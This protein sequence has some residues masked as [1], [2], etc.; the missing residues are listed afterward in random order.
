MDAHKRYLIDANTLLT[1]KNLYYNF[2]IAPTFWKRMKACAKEGR[3][4]TIDKVMKEWCVSKEDEDKDKLQLWIEN[5]F[6]AEIVQT[7]QTKIIAGYAKILN[8]IQSSPSYNDRALKAW[9]EEKIADAWLI[10]TCME[11]DYVL[12]TLETSKSN[13]TPS[14]SKPKIPDFC[15]YFHVPCIDLFTMMLE[16]KI[17]L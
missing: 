13:P 4:L 12:V 16:L 10:A 2:Q 14:A 3:I 9:S 15:G 8:F 7:T 5:E 1:A 6:E 17:I 11:Y